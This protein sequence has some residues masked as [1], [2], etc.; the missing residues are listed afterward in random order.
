MPAFPTK[1]DATSFL[2]PSEQA[3]DA[4]KPTGQRTSWI[5]KPGIITG[6]IRLKYGVGTNKK[7]DYSYCQVNVQGTRDF[8]GSSFQSKIFFGNDIDAIRLQKTNMICH[9]ALVVA[10]KPGSSEEKLKN[11][12]AKIAEIVNNAKDW[13]ETIE[14]L[15][16]N[17]FDNEGFGW[18][19]DGYAQDVQI[20]L[21][22]KGEYISLPMPNSKTYKRTVAH[23]GDETF[24]YSPEK[25]DF[26]D[27]RPYKKK[28]EAPEP[29]KQPRRTSWD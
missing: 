9:I 11:A 27:E 28:E 26:N 24:T 21:I 15:N 25:D 4:Q 6:Y 29:K 22:R 17:I 5:D 20:K 2:A 8:A 12:A 1:T 13:R 3:E 16:I 18:T 14:E 7:G 19:E 10:S 23:I